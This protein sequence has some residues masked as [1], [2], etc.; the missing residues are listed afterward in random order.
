MNCR[1]FDLFEFMRSEPEVNLFTLSVEGGEALILACTH[2]RGDGAH[3]GLSDWYD[4]VE[5]GLQQA[6][7]L[8]PGLQWTTGW[9]S[10]KK[11]IASGRI[12]CMGKVLVAKASVSDDFDTP[13]IGVYE[14]AHTT[15]LEEVRTAINI[16]WDRA[17]ADQKD[18]QNYRGFSV[19]DGTGAWIETVIIPFSAGHHLDEPPGDCYHQWG[20]QGESDSIPADTLS[21]L[22]EWAS[23]SENEGPKTINGFTIKPWED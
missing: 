22:V 15:D 23:D 8:G 1:I 19:H 10:S 2:N 5:Q 7:D 21:A 20:P 11:A 6:L 16:A 9:Y 13:G 12:D 4:E 17:E 3:C 14:M 18:N